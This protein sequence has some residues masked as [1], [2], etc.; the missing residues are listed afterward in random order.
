M[1][2][3]I[4]FMGYCISS[5]NVNNTNLQAA[6]FYISPLLHR[7]LATVTEQHG[8]WYISWE[9]NKLSTLWRSTD[10]LTG[11]KNLFRGPLEYLWHSKNELTIELK[12]TLMYKREEKMAYNSTYAFSA[13]NSSHYPQKENKRKQ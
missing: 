8:H 5:I 12:S 3:R 9:E 2:P 7:I 10:T 13:L 11:E 4:Y 1:F 6:L